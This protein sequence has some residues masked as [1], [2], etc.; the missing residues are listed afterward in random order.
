MQG[1]QRPGGTHTGTAAR[2][3]DVAL[4][5]TPRGLQQCHLSLFSIS[6]F[7]LLEWSLAGVALTRHRLILVAV[8]CDEVRELAGHLHDLFIKARS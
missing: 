4:F 2:Q 8:L 1:C 6:K 3:Q 7:C 5:A